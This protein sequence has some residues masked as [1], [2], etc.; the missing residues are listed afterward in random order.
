MNK[1]IPKYMQY[2]YFPG[3]LWI[4]NSFNLRLS[5]KHVAEGG[6]LAEEVVSTIRTAQAFG[7]QNVLA[8]MYD[9]AVQKA[10]DADCRLAVVRGIG[11]SCFFFAIY[12][13][14]GLGGFNFLYNHKF[15]DSTRQYLAFSFGA[16]LINQ[17]H[18]DPG[19]IAN[20][21]MA[22][23]IGLFSFAMIAP[24]MQGT[25]LSF[26][27]TIKLLRGECLHFLS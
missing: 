13:V 25:S 11:F 19:Q 8:S 14:Y 9:V 7:T 10:Y 5:L 12:A 17:G 2:V 18:A 15:T 24:E 20:V 26:Y 23:L 16:T 1:F 21:I 6:S 3:V 27:R 4:A 22:I